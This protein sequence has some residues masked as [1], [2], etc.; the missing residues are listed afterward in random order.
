MIKDFDPDIEWF[1]PAIMTIYILFPLIYEILKRIKSF[2]GELILVIICVMT[3]NITAQWL[4]YHFTVR[5]PLVILG[6]LTYKY[7]KIT[8]GNNRN[9]IFALYSFTAMMVLGSLNSIVQYAIIVP[10]LLY[11]FNS[12]TINKSVSRFFVVLGIF[13]YE[14]YL[15]QVI[16]TYYILRHQLCLSDGLYQL[17]EITIYTVLL[18]VLFAKVSSYFNN[19]LLHRLL[20]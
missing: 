16:T 9:K 10:L 2:W 4:D 8:E 15:S 14:I 6:I 19:Y 18:S 1:T 12:L 17:L 3:T 20:K 11:G 5:I 13:S 7:L